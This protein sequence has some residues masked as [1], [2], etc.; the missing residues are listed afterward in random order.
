MRVGAL[1]PGW[2][3]KSVTVAGRNA[4]DDA[5]DVGEAGQDEIVVTLTPRG[6]EILG[7]VRDARTQ[8]VAGAAI[9]IIPISANGDT[10]WTPHRTR[11]TRTNA[12]GVFAIS[13]LPPGD[14]YA[15]AIDDASAEGWQDTAV[16][17]S[18][19][20]LATRITLRDQEFRTLNLRLS[21]LKR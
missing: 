6:T 1:P 13:G 2:Y 4:L 19:R 11:E 5:I 8:V 21:T 16:V 15:V 12:G 17:A 14:Y 9:I 20:A 10:A 3:L 18:L 7:T